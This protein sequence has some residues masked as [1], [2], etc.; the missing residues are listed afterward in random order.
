MTNENGTPAQQ[1]KR[2]RFDEEVTI[3]KVKTPTKDTPTNA[4]TELTSRAVASYPDQIKVL[5][6]SISRDY[7]AL[8]LKQRQQ[9]S[10]LAKLQEDSFIPRSARVSFKLTAP[11]RVMDTDDFKQHK[12]TVD[13][14]LKRFQTA[15][16]KAIVET[17][18]LVDKDLQESMSELLVKA[19]INLSTFFLILKGRQDFSTYRCAYYLMGK[20]VA[21]SVLAAT[22]SNRI[23]ATK[24]IK[25]SETNQ[26]LMDLEA[27]PANAGEAPPAEPTIWTFTDP[28]ENQ[29]LDSL[30]TDVCGLLHIIFVDS[31]AAQ[32]EV[33][34]KKATETALAI[35]AK[36]ILGVPATN[37]ANQ[38]LDKEQTAGPK[39]IKDLIEQSVQKKTKSLQSE[40]ARL[41]QQIQRTKNSQGGSSR[42]QPTAKGAPSSKTK[43]DNGNKGRN[44]GKGKGQPQKQKPKGPPPAKQDKNSQHGASKKT[45]R[46]SLSPAQKKKLATNTTNNK[47]SRPSTRK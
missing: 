28:A 1:R 41:N 37:K 39:K 44:N 22:W 38:E 23:D 29:F 40:V 42:Q 36:K 5:V 18:K 15:L 12:T 2:V 30:M 14:A 20:H 26:E 47:N 24:K 9:V 19:T 3:T 34:N 21:D 33:Y 43:D 7:N 17:A 35:A 16:K 46:R 13:A 4:A 10:S 31:W 32:V 25:E 45:Q 6:T 27:P 8:C 11:D